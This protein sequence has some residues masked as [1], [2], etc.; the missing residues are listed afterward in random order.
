MSPNVYFLFVQQ[1][2]NKFGVIAF[3]CFKV[4]LAPVSVDNDVIAYRQTEPRALSG[5]FGGEKRIEYFAAGKS[6]SQEVSKMVQR[7]KILFILL[8]F[9]NF[10]NRLKP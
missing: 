8:P 10:L 6:P 3:F 4:D 2:N 5:W 9:G 1:A 7:S